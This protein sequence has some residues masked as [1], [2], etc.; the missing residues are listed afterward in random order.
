MRDPYYDEQSEDVE[1]R[2]GRS[3]HSLGGRNSD[4]IFIDK[5]VIM[6]VERSLST[7]V[8]STNSGNSSLPPA[9][10]STSTHHYPPIWLR[11]PNTSFGISMGLAGQAIMWRSATNASFITDFVE[12]DMISIFVWLFSLL[13]GVLLFGAY[14]LKFYFYGSLC[15][16]E[17]KDSARVHFFNMPHLIAIM[18]TI[19][20]PTDGANMVAGVTP[21]GQRIVWVVTFIIQTI[22]TQHIYENWLFSETHT[23]S[24]ARPQFLLSTVGWMLLAILGAQLDIEDAWGVPLPTWCLG[25]GNMLYLMVAISVFNALHYAPK[26]K[27]SPALFLLIA[28]PSAAVVA[29]D[30]L[31][32]DP[33]SFSFTAKML[34]GW[35]MGLFLLLVRIGPKIWQAPPSLGAYWAYVFPLSAL[36]TALIRC[37]VVADTTG[38]KILALIFMAIAILAT[39]AVWIRMMVH[40][41]RVFAGYTEWGDPLLSKAH[42]NFTSVITYSEAYP[43]IETA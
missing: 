8:T 16:D 15:M 30:L 1:E 33:D 31:D 2:R 42:L 32:G 18:L 24:C 17:Y 7:A 10:S 35:C 38:A 12:T 4:S 22:F 39:A 43:D 11:L 3:H 23:I 26:A 21:T 34:L 36:A 9:I 37:A 27:G 13:I 19:S 28:P 29:L 25:F 6:K 5:E 40:A 41:Y 14:S 20:V